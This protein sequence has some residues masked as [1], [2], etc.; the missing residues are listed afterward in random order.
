MQQFADVICLDPRR[1]FRPLL[2]N[3]LPTNSV[4]EN[5]ATIREFKIVVQRQS[6][7]RENGAR[8]REFRIVVQR[9]PSLSR[10][11]SNISEVLQTSKHMTSSS[12]I[13]N[14]VIT[15]WI[16]FEWALTLQDRLSA[17]ARCWTRC[18]FDVSLAL[19]G[20]ICEP[21]LPFRAFLAQ[22][23]SSESSWGSWAQSRL[24]H[25]YVSWN[26]AGRV[27]W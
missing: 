22:L 4:R 3:R 2:L 12:S 1:L 18:L 16:L 27:S 20:V 8:I 21:S 15:C 11:F 13:N 26:I 17:H 5:G 24:S 23:S 10:K 6:C 19:L 14:T 7:V 25:H 9:V